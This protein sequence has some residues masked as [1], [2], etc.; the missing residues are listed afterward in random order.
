MW[1]VGW[2][3][4]LGRSQNTCTQALRVAWASSQ[5]GGWVPRERVRQKLDSGLGSSIAPYLSYSV[6]CNSHSLFRFKGR[7][8]DFSAWWSTVKFW[9]SVWDWKYYCGHVLG[10]WSAAVAYMLDLGYFSAFPSSPQ[11][12]VCSSCILWE[13]LGPLLSWGLYIG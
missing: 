11:R 4:H 2:D 10:I 6:G 1:A 8:I 12:T 13:H 5:H 3:H 9:K 7:E